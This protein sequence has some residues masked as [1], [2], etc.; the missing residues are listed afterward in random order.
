M[1]VDIKEFFN[2]LKKGVLAQDPQASITTQ[3]SG[4]QLSCTID[5]NRA[6]KSMAAESL[7][8]VAEDDLVHVSLEENYTRAGGVSTIKAG[9]F[10]TDADFL[11]K[12]AGTIK[13]LTGYHH[14]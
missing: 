10:D 3:D 2:Q 14:T 13:T 4:L 12:V 7:L 6:F 8:I 5:A 1:T 11:A 9:D